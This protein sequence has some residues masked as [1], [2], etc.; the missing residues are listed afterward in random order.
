MIVC[1]ITAVCNII[2][3]A[4]LIPKYAAYGAAISTAFNGLLILILL[5]F[6]VDKRI[7]IDRIHDIFIGPLIG[8]AG[9]AGCCLVFRGVGDFWL[10]VIC[11]VVSSGVVY[12]VILLITKNEFGIE[13]VNTLKAKF[14]QK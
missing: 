10:R 9:I 4:L 11:S 12:A 2:L 7:K 14:N 5:L 8:C 6:K 13:I 1:C 3:N